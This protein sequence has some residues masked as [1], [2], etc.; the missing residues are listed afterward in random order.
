MTRRAWLATLA[1]LAARAG[2]GKKVAITGKLSQ[3]PSGKPVLEI[4][5]GKAAVVEGDDA[6]NAVLRDARL[7]V[8]EMELIGEFR[9]DS[10]FAVGPIHTQSMFV[11]RDGKRFTIS[12]WCDLCAIRTYTPGRCMCCQQ[13]TE[14]DLREHNAP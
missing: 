1:A 13:E 6:T 9:G 11:L 10:V 8:R 2:E 5:G 12:Y 7:A 14:L 4:G 3:D